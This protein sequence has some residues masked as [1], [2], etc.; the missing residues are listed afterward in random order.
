MNQEASTNTQQ[1]E[2]DGSPRLYANFPRRLDALSLDS[3]V[4]VAFSLLVFAVLAPL[5]EDVNAVRIGLVICWWVVLLLYEPVLAWRGGTIG[6]RIMNLRVV[7]NRTQRNVS[8]VKALARFGLKGFLGILSFFTMNFSRRHQA[9][10]DILTNSSVQI[11][12]ATKAQ[13]H[14]YTVGRA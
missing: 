2:M 9:A 6:H 3:V 10:H 14:H 12:D 1:G 7:D 11:R 8:L 5:F 13:P 4:L